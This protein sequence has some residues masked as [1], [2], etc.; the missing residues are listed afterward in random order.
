MGVVYL[1]EQRSPL[2]EVAV[3]ILPP[4]CNTASS[5]RRFEI[6]AQTLATLDHPNIARVLSSGITTAPDGGE[7]AYI[8]MDYVPGARDILKYSDER[9]LSAVERARLFLHCLGAIELAHHRGIVHCDIKP[10]NVLVS[11]DGEVKVIDFGIARAASSPSSSPLTSSWYGTVEYAAPES[12]RD[13]SSLPDLRSDIYSLGIVLAELWTGRRPKSEQD[14]PPSSDDLRRTIRHRPRPAFQILKRALAHSPE[15]RYQSVRELRLDLERWI[16][17]REL[18]GQGLPS[19]VAR[20]SHL[21]VSAKWP[22]TAALAVGSLVYL[23]MLLGSPQ[24]T[25]SAKEGESSSTAYRLAMADAC[26]TLSTGSL[27]WGAG[28]SL[29]RDIPAEHRAWDF[30]VLCGLAAKGPRTFSLDCVPTAACMPETGSQIVVGDELGRVSF[31]STELRSNPK[32]AWVSDAPIREIVELANSFLAVD[33]LG[34]AFVVDREANCTHGYSVSAASAFV[35]DDSFWVVSNDRLE[36]IGA[37]D[38]RIRKRIEIV[39]VPDPWT[40]RLSEFD[41]TPASI[42]RRNGTVRVHGIGPENQIAA[43]FGGVLDA[44]W[45]GV[46]EMLLLTA[47][48]GP[49]VWRSGL[50]STLK[51]PALSA[52]R[53]AVSSGATRIALGTS[54]GEVI[55]ADW[56][57]LVERIRVSAHA[58]PVSFVAISR[59]GGAVA[60]G[61]YDRVVRYWESIDHRSPQQRQPASPNYRVVGVSA[62][63]RF[64]ASSNDSGI[65]TAGLADEPEGRTQFVAPGVA[66]ACIAISADGRHVAL[67]FADDCSWVLDTEDGKARRIGHFA[68]DC[69]SMMFVDA[70]RLVTL[71]TNGRLTVSSIESS[72]EY[73]SVMLDRPTRVSPRYSNRLGLTCDGRITVFLGGQSVVAATVDVRSGTVAS[74]A[75]REDHY[76][77]LLGAYAEAKRTWCV[78]DTS[79]VLRL[80][81]EGGGAPPA[82]NPR[83]IADGALDLE[84]SP[85]GNVLALMSRSGSITFVHVDSLETTGTVV[86]AAEPVGGLTILRPSGEIVI[87]LARGELLRLKPGEPPREVHLPSF[88][89]ENAPMAVEVLEDGGVAP[90]ARTTGEEG[91][92]RVALA[93]RDLNQK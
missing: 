22:A 82:S 23:A 88:G 19:L 90:V 57:A 69:L 75:V 42:S 86:T 10:S 77:P 48:N 74:T 13:R 41:G 47:T 52:D 9:Q 51:L 29:L 50:T 67:G 59:D 70:S 45:L 39:E 73:W 33:D 20:G 17:G 44:R 72:S 21:F 34:R 66:P 76:Q 53:A 65:V 63:A 83:R 46:S 81:N 87:P 8:A 43:G 14:L 55:V 80:I 89:S 11:K 35:G 78:L 2:R 28:E 71:N 54:K 49:I 56:P 40:L 30:Q 3:K 16:D 79:G 31:H 4:N 26:R 37:D 58:G 24:R 93:G 68:D 91:E 84:V 36:E 7:L 5:L 92:D 25:T 64:F 1:A 85:D 62:D 60:S 27:K 12:I 32:Y 15:E 18:Q 61:G 6:E 38:S